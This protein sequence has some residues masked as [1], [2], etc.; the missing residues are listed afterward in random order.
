MELY[1]KA[2]LELNDA[3][4]KAEFNR[5]DYACENGK[6]HFTSKTSEDSD[7]SFITTINLILTLVSVASFLRKVFKFNKPEDNEKV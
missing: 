2:K 6:C 3:F 5:R 1:Q 4:L 7:N